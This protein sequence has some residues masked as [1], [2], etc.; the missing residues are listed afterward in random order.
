MLSYVGKAKEKMQ[1]NRPGTAT[2]S[3]M[4]SRMQSS[5]MQGSNMKNVKSKVNTGSQMKPAS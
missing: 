5:R 4:G 3:I 1:N 2:R